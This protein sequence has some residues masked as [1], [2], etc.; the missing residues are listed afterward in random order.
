[1]GD[2]QKTSGIHRPGDETQRK[3]KLQ[4]GMVITLGADHMAQERDKTGAR[5]PC[6]SLQM[7]V[8]RQQSPAFGRTGQAFIGGAR[9]GATIAHPARA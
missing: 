7:H 6:L 4:V 5:P 9:H 3:S 2:G 1:M 8:H